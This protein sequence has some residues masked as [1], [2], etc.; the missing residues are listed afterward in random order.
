MLRYVFVYSKTISKFTSQ[1][2]RKMDET[3][4]FDV[5]ISY[6]SKDI[7]TAESIRDFL[8]DKIATSDFNPEQEIVVTNG[9]HYEALRKTEE[10]LSRLVE[11]LESGVSAD[12]L[13]QDLREADRYLGEITGAIS[14]D[15][16]LHTVFARYCI[17]K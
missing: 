14:S 13:A 11:G 4:L 3:G 1:I 2:E 6:S 7:E 10:P 17:G 9:R 12:F 16:I 5:F 15:E 8:E